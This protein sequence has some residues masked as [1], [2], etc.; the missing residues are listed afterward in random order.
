MSIS[1]M[2]WIRLDK[3]FE[4]TSKL[5]NKQINFNANSIIFLTKLNKEVINGVPIKSFLSIYI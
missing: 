2:E 4:V 3:C 1:D 5:I